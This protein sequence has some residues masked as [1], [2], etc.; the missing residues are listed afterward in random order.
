MPPLQGKVTPE[1]AKINDSDVTYVNGIKVGATEL[2]AEARRSY[3]IPAGV[4]KTGINNI[5]VW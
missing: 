1:L 3:T 2:R 5:T 4:L